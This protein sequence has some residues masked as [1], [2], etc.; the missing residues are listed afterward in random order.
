MQHQALA[1]MQQHADHGT[2]KKRHNIVIAARGFELELNLSAT[3]NQKPN[4]PRHPEQHIGTVNTPIQAVILLRAI[5]QRN[6]CPSHQH[7]RLAYR[8]LGFH[9]AGQ[10]QLG[11]DREPTNK[12]IDQ[13]EPTCISNE[14]IQNGLAR[15]NDRQSSYHS[16]TRK[17]KPAASERKAAMNIVD[18]CQPLKHLKDKALAYKSQVISLAE[19]LHEKQLRKQARSWLCPQLY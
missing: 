4:D 6:G 9:D 7:I 5:R 2:E 17:N 18:A 13:G 10:Q 8:G 16:G 14:L 12:I 3:G 19:R 11:T 1:L 15:T